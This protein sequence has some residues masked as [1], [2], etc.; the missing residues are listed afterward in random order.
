MLINNYSTNIIVKY[1]SIFLNQNY[2]T[3]FTVTDRYINNIY[4]NF[5][6]NDDCVCSNIIGYNYNNSTTSD[7]LNYCKIDYVGGTVTDIVIDANEVGSNILIT[8]PTTNDFGS[9]SLLK[10]KRLLYQVQTSNIC[11]G[12]PLKEQY[13]RFMLGLTNELTNEEKLDFITNFIYVSIPEGEDEE[14]L[15]KTYNTSNFLNKEI[16]NNDRFFEDNY[17]I[18]I[19]AGNIIYC[20]KSTMKETNSLVANI[21]MYISSRFPVLINRN[22]SFTPI[23][24]NGAFISSANNEPRIYTTTDEL[25]SYNLT[26]IMKADIC[27]YFTST[28]KSFNSEKGDFNL[29]SFLCSFLLDRAITP[30][31]SMEDIT[32]V[33]KLL[34]SDLYIN[35]SA[36]HYGI[37]DSN[38]TNTLYDYQI[39]LNKRFS[40]NKISIS[41]SS[42]DNS[43]D[44][45][46]D[47]NYNVI[48][49]TGYFDIITEK[50]LLQDKA[51]IQGDYNDGYSSI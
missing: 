39:S 31:S 38:L 13:R 27:K 28:D 17:S 37:W 7:R 35:Y 15:I 36:N 49:P 1:I 6:I 30:L 19:D 44:T 22:I 9:N 14:N 33:Q 43:I 12:K 51:L 25:S 50:Y 41:D 23:N 4:N 42:N 32:Y 47:V 26:E 40:N 8:S 3:S 46:Y 11:Y 48:I 10:K 24:N 2:N 29:D 45:L 34:E 16:N 5:S 20:R 18:K 21:A